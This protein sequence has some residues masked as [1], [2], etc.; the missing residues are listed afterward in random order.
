MGVQISA[1]AKFLSSSVSS[2]NP[3]WTRLRPGH[4]EMKTTP[5][6]MLGRHSIEQMIPQANTETIASASDVSMT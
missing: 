1:L 3:V 4:R 5:A 6:V 2:S